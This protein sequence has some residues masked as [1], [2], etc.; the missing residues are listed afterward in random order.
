MDLYLK[1]IEEIDKNGAKLNS[2]IEINP[3]AISIAKQMDSERKEG[4]VRGLLHGIPV[5]I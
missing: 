2:I 1:R 5:V 4:K 3:E